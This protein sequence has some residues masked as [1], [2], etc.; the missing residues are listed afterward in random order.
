MVTLTLVSKAIGVTNMVWDVVKQMFFL[1]LLIVLSW[2]VIHIFA[3]LGIFIIITY[4]LWVLINPQKETCLFCLLRG[5]ANSCFMCSEDEYDQPSKKKPVRKFL[6]NILLLAFMIFFSLGIVWGEKYLLEQLGAISPPKT[7]VM[8]MSM[9]NEYRIGELFSM[10]LEIH[11]LQVPINTVQI[12]LKYPPELLEIVEVLTLDSFA[13]IFLQR[14]VR[15]DLGIARISG[16]LPNPG[17]SKESGL[18]AKVLFLTKSSGLGEVQ[19]LPSSMVLANDGKGTNV[20]AEFRSTTFQISEEKVSKIEEEFQNSFLQSN[21]LG[22][23][24]DK[25]EFFDKETVYTES[26]L[27]DFDYEEV[28][29]EPINFW[30]LLY[31]INTTIISVYTVILPN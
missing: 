24:S 28:R 21:I 11:G 29:R 5:E 16:G 25:M 6:I 3:V 8:E 20:L 4:P 27:D 18:F 1:I 14:E 31:R 13:E 15:N 2:I 17:Y 10:P 9:K 19:I 22:A 26:I 12:D 30:D 23:T 7:I